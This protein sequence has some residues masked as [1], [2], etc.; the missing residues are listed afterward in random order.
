MPK[1]VLRIG[2]FVKAQYSSP[3]VDPRKDLVYGKIK[4]MDVNYLYLDGIL[5][6]Q[7]E[8]W[9]SHDIPCSRTTAEAFDDKEL[10]E[11]LEAHIGLCEDHRAL[12]GALSSSKENL[13][14]LIERRDYDGRMEKN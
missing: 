2:Q 3:R 10:K 9:Y 6:H 14:F 8:V 5:C 12:T 7:E 1:D 13:E 11:R 4:A